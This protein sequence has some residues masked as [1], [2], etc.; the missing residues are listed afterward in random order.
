MPRIRSFALLIV[1]LSISSVVSAAPNLK[2]IKRGL[3]E[4]VAKNDSSE[5]CRLL[6]KLGPIND[7][8]AAKLAI[9]VTATN[10][11]L[12]LADATVAQLAAMDSPKVRK[13][14]IK[15]S[16]AA[17]RWWERLLILQALAE[18]PEPG[19][20]A[21]LLAATSDPHGSVLEQLAEILE[22]KRDIASLEAL[23][24]LCE[25][26]DAAGQVDAARAG[27][28]AL[29]RLTGEEG[30]S[31]GVDWRNWWSQAKADFKFRSKES[32]KKGAKEGGELSTVTRRIKDRDEGTFI[33][34]LTE[35]DVIVV[36]G[37]FD[38]VEKA[39][40]KLG[41]PFTLV[42]REKFATLKLNPNQ[43]LIFNCHK[44]PLD[45][46]SLENLARFVSAGGYVFTSDWELRNI[47]MRSFPGVFVAKAQIPEGEVGII[48]F[49]ASASHAYLRDVF[50]K[51]PYKLA[52]YK[53]KIDAASDLLSFAPDKGVTPLIF[54]HELEKEHK[55]GVVAL[56]FR[57]DGGLVGHA[58]KRKRKRVRTGKGAS[59]EHYRE[60]AGGSVLHVLGHFHAQ[61]DDSGDGYALQQLLANFIVEK[62]KFRAAQVGKKK[63]KKRRKR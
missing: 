47:L 6:R 31:V 18:I 8:K 58:K 57:W 2:R 12:D 28:A 38:Q 61:M 35:G 41:I 48:P 44:E 29:R 16:K 5:T 25:T 33:R 40:E 56:T 49:L 39:V 52:K 26:A 42:E 19:T 13:H 27:S 62:Q 4:A 34:E 24:A 23:I 46:K 7:V 9:L 22:S 30:L 50:P 15:E 3:A 51:N 14:L 11:H 1:C 60:L 32:K 21:A 36:K 17:K 63:R 37:V 55:L 43:V 20:R 53:W 59:E 10:L 45:A 54:S